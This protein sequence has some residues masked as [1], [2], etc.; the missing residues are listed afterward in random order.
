[1]FTCQGCGAVLAGRASRVFC[2]NACQRE[3]ERQLLVSA[4][5]ATGIAHPGT[6]RHHY[7]R[8]FLLEAQAG[9]CARCGVRSEWNGEPLAFVLDHVDGDAENNRRENLRLVCP[10]CDSQLPTYKSRNRGRGRHARRERYARGE[11]Y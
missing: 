6:G 10:N 8:R 5:L 2:S 4:W 7:V 1:M 9:S 11:S 3:K